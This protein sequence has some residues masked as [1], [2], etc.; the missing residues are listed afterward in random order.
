MLEAACEEYLIHN[1]KSGKDVGYLKLYWYAQQY[2][3]KFHF[4]SSY[5]SFLFFT[6]GQNFGSSL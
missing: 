4:Q 5:F 3:E 6:K 2:G 1:V